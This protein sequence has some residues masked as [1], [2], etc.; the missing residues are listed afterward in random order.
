MTD[1]VSWHLRCRDG[2]PFSVSG[3]GTAYELGWSVFSFGI[4]TLRFPF[5]LS[6]GRAVTTGGY[7]VSGRGLNSVGG[8]TL[9]G[10]YLGLY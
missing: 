9:P 3:W 4:D 10:A 1:A 8:R 2:F 7:V 5:L 6:L